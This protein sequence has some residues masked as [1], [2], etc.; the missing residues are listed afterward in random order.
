MYV[1]SFEYILYAQV[2][3]PVDIKAIVQSLEA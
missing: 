3:F 2:A 1:C